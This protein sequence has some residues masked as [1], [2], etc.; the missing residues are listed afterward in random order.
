MVCCR[1]SHHGL[2]V[3]MAQHKGNIRHIEDYS[4]D[5]M[6]GSL[7]QDLKVSYYCARHNFPYI[8]G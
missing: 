4:D 2:L 5:F 3:E 7:A 6:Q 8:R 1:Q